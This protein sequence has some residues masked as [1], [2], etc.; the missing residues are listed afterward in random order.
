MAQQFL[1]FAETSPAAA[2]TAI[3]SAAV[4]GS[5]GAAGVAMLTAGLDS[6]LSLTVVAKLVGATG[7]TLDVYLQSS[8]DQGTTWVDYAH[9]PQLAAGAAAVR[10][11]FA[12]AQGVQSAAPV[13][14]GINGAPALAAN[15]IVGGAWGDRLRLVMVAGA[16]TTIG[17]AVNITISAQKTSS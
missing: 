2:G 11:A 5:S 16:A 7:G 17:A 14:V 6:F 8:P 12:T 4:A 15:T 10:Y 9:F 1:V 13:V 3:S